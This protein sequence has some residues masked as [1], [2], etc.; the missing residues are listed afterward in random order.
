MVTQTYYYL[1]IQPDLR[2]SKKRRFQ[3]IPGASKK[4][5]YSR[6]GFFAKQKNMLRPKKPASLRDTLSTFTEKKH[7]DHIN[8]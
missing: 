4:N 5:R 2:R 8:T 1:E 6:M 7:L 3:Q